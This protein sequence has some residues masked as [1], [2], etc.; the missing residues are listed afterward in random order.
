VFSRGVVRDFHADEG[1]GV[2]DGPDVPGGCW[3]HFS[4]IMMGGHRRLTP[5][6]RIS[7]HAEVADQDAFRFRA[8]SV[9]LEGGEPTDPSATPATSIGYRSALLLRFDQPEDPPSR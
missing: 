6:Q 1:W 7:F 3:F 2:V 4:A 9:R 5:G 8:S